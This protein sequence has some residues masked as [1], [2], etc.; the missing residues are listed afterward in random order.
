V[1]KRR[2]AGKLLAIPTADGTF[3]YPLC[4]F[5]DDGL[6]TGLEEALAALQV[7]SPWERLSALVNPSPALGGQPAITVLAGARTAEEKNQ[8]LAVLR[9]FLQ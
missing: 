9:E 2:K 1:D 4:Q 6:V 5:S 3:A 8:A 7:D